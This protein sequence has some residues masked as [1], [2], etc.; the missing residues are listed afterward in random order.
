M[1]QS[2]AIDRAKDAVRPAC[3]AACVCKAQTTCVQAI[4]SSRLRCWTQRDGL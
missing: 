3:L 2:L 1:K 4:Y